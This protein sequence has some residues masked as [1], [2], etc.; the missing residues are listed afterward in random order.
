[1]PRRPKTN[2]VSDSAYDK[3]F[4]KGRGLHYQTRSKGVITER[5]Q[6]FKLMKFRRLK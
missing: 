1:M 2:I 4:G 6:M 5:F 3:V